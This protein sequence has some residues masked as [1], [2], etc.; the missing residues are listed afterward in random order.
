MLA[1]DF[2]ELRIV[3]VVLHVGI[4]IQNIVLMQLHVYTAADGTV[5]RCSN[6][7]QD[8]FMSCM[9]VYEYKNVVLMQLHVFT[10]ADG[11]ECLCF[12]KVHLVR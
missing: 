8:C 10:A 9:L 3:F 5:C 7:W 11:T 2:I 6:C 1:T 4:R 12:C